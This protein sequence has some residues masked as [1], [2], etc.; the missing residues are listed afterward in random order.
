MTSAPFGEEGHEISHEGGEHEVFDNVV[1][2]LTLA[3]GV[4]RYV[5]CFKCLDALKVWNRNR[6]YDSR[7][8]RDRTLRRI[9]AWAPQMEALA[10]AYLYFNQGSPP[11]PLVGEELAT[12]ILCI[13]L[14]GQHFLITH[15]KC[16]CLMN[17]RN[18]TIDSLSS[19]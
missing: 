13:D 8:R 11:P 17:S 16:T 3:S 18:Q 14:F 15:S 5:C 4:N 1:E 12:T 10:N 7:T 2:E 6:R 19:P 9:A